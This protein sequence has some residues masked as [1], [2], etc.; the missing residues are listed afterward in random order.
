MRLKQWLA[1]PISQYQSIG[2]LPTTPDPDLDLNFPLPIVSQCGGSVVF[3][4]AWWNKCVDAPS[5][6]AIFG[7]YRYIRRSF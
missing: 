1:A 2:D 5:V 6:K 7:G 3:P 4:R